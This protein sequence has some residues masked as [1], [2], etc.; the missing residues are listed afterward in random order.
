MI[1]TRTISIPVDKVAGD[2]FDAIFELFPKII[3]D[4]KINSNGWWSFIGPYGKSKL[5]FN[6]DR[7]LGIL[8][9]LYIDEEST[10]N[11]PMRI[12]PNGDFSELVIVL[13]KPPQLTDLQFDD[14]VEKIN[15]LVF[16]MK[17][18]LESKS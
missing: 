6:S 8:D 16:S 18:L 9:P 5:R 12:I 4:A 14:R 10:W 7:S 2:T 13:T 11:I 1:R 15:E 3:P 17:T